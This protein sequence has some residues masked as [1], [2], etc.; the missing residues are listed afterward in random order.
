MLARYLAILLT[1]LSTASASE[2]LPGHRLKLEDVLRSST[3]IVLASFRSNGFRSLG[4]SGELYYERV[5]IRIVASL[6]GSLTG[7]IVAGYR[8]KAMPGPD[9]EVQPSLGP[10][11]ILFINGADSNQIEMNKALRSDEVNLQQLRLAIANRGST[12]Q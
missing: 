11:Y 9:K 12:G 6:K 5:K 10:E 1:A 2:L 4:T 8:L 7:D 3:D